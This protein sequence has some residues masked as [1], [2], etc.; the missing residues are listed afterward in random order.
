LR[1]GG[2]SIP[3]GVQGGGGEDPRADLAVDW[4]YRY[5]LVATACGQ[6]I[7]D[8]SFMTGE[9]VWGGSLRQVLGY[10]P[11]E[12]DGGFDQWC[13][14]IDPAD[15]DQ[16]LRCLE[17]ARADNTPFEM[18]YGFR[19]KDGRYLRML[20]R[21][22]P[23]PDGPVPCER[24]VGLMQN[25]TA[26]RQVEASIRY[27]QKMEAV[28]LLAAGVAHDFNNMLQVMN[29]FT[30]MTRQE[31]G[32]AHPSGSML[33]EVLKAGERAARLTGQLLAF[34]RQQIMHPELLDFNEV[35]SA[36]TT[37][38][39]RL[40]GERIQ[41]E[42]AGAPILETVRA[43]RGQMEH[44]LLNLA[45]NARDAMPGGGRLRIETANV[46]LSEATRLANGLAGDE[47]FVSVRVADTGCGIPAEMRD[48]I[49]EPFFTTRHVG[50]GTGLG[51]ATVYGILRQHGGLIEVDSQPGA[52]AAFTFYLPAVRAAP[53]ELDA[54]EPM[55][56]AGGTET[57]VLAEDNDGVREL[58][59]RTLSGA[60]YTVLEA[61][62]GAEA[63]E[64]CQARGDE[65]A[66][67]LLDVMMPELGG[68]EA[69]RRLRE[70]HPH[71]Q[72]LFMTGY[73]QDVE[74]INAVRESGFEL[75]LKPFN[76]GVLLARL[77]QLLD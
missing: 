54:D 28:G 39:T 20:D 38:L 6:V 48:R 46:R 47:W 14:L 24:M 13:D 71:L 73:S 68:F 72:F 3:A 59:R 31:L 74:Q 8:C 53:G 64:I 67:V 7:Y 76:C 77:R 2:R 34:S 61:T 52:G 62:N 41:V 63:V 40:V 15:R 37:M 66:L 35:I 9:V 51:L 16:V 57:V 12:M 30:E 29:G 17:A 75:L 33:D 56:A 25:V 19:H 50:K 18:E 22:Y 49:F 11:A 65:V 5:E 4:K 27:A 26:Q 10:E 1:R 36:F 43:D 45:M 44:V 58:I 69:C 21:G 60:G 23:A 70:A 55:A 32:P 42:F